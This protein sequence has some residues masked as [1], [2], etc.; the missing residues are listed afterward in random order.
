MI[1]VFLFLTWFLFILENI[2]ASSQGQEIILNTGWK[3]KRSI[4][5][6]V[7]GSV[8]TSQEFVLYDWMD[9]KIPGT[10]LTTLLHNGKIPDPFF[11]NNNEQ[12]PDIYFTGRDFYTYWFFN[13]FTLPERKNKKVCWLKFRGINYSA[14]IFLN[15]TRVNKRPHRGMF[16]REKYNIT[17][18]VDMVKPNRLAVLVEPP[19]P[20]GNPNGGQGGDGQIGK[21]VTNQFVAGWDWIQPI[22]DRNTGIWDKVS[23]EITGPVDIRNPFI[24]ARIPGKR[25]PGTIQ[26]PAWI[27]V[28]AELVNGTGQP[29]TGVL[30]IMLNGEEKTVKVELPPQDKV[31]VTFPEWQIRNPK[32]WWPNGYG[33][34]NLYQLHLNVEM[35]SGE[36]SDNESATFGLRQTGTYFDREIGARVFLVNGQKIFIRGGNWIASDAMLRLSPERYEAEVRMHSEMNMNMIRIWGGSITERPEFY[37]ACDKYGILVMQDLWITGDC[38][39]R[40]NDTRKKDSQARRRDYPDDHSLFLES[41]ADQVKMLR[42]H[43]SLYVWCGGNEYPPPPDINDVLQNELFPAL[44][45]TRY[46]L[47]ES[48]S[49]SL[50]T[51]T[52]GGN[53]D[54]P[55]NIRD[56]EW[57]FSFKSYPFN[58]EIGSVGLPNVETL[59]KIMNEKDMV[60]PRGFRG[61]PVWRFHKYSG[62]GN[63]IEQYGT[64]ENI[65]DFCFKAQIVNYEQYR[66]LLEGFNANM[67]NWYTGVLIWKNQNPW[68]ALRGMLY[69][70]FLDQTGGFYGVKHGS[71]PIH[72]QLNLD[73]STVCIVNHTFSHLENMVA[74]AEIYDLHGKE[75]YREQK[76]VSINPSSVSE[77]FTIH[78][79]GVSNDVFFVRLILTNQENDLISENF[80]W[81]KQPGKDY[82]ILKDLKRV[83]LNGNAKILKK[84]KNNQVVLELENLDEEIAFFIRLK[85]IYPEK[86]ELVLPV[87]YE[88]NYFTILPGKSR[89]VT[90]E[91]PLKL[92]WEKK[93]EI[94]LEGWNIS[95]MKI[96]IR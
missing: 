34:Q 87:F 53:G 89:K 72:I 37:N 67:W 8:I 47:D 69:D 15:G 56:P 32:L 18:L 19:D 63:F 1:K 2:P 7:D 6:P 71:E 92:N 54:G 61:P 28:S 62:Y 35:E 41:V 21:S 42:N 43:P 11:G 90:I 59:K 44:D 96:P 65:K 60:P 58:P 31:V 23:L 84:G 82:T 3:A 80:Y 16:L 94:E 49:D 93:P 86:G 73:D 70:F 83:N 30:K 85:I 68:S 57:F 27:T 78:A 13:S 12:I 39:G 55:Y 75:I 17:Q 77:L 79:S 22:R 81:L 5:I 48:T 40:W 26:A 4:E 52:I 95:G 9:A 91:L 14:N 64:P 66:A 29:Q 36:L 46:Y 25:F 50:L 76:Q 51:N 74:I 20:A 10:V 45:G 38:N 24:K 33:E 88:E